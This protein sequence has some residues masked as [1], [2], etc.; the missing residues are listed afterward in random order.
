[1]FS[2]AIFCYSDL[3]PLLGILF[4]FD[5]NTFC[6]CFASSCFILPDCIF[7]KNSILLLKSSNYLLALEPLK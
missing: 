6:N 1:M 7:L 3:F 5:L 4:R 2:N